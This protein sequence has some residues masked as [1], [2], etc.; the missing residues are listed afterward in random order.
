MA[1]AWGGTCLFHGP[2]DGRGASVSPLSHIHHVPIHPS[3]QLPAPG[4][5]P[6]SG[7]LEHEGFRKDKNQEKSLAAPVFWGSAR[8]RDYS[9]NSHVC[10]KR[11]QTGVSAPHNVPTSTLPG[12]LEAAPVLVFSPTER[13]PPGSSFKKHHT[14]AGEE[15]TGQKELKSALWLTALLQC[16]VPLRRDDKPCLLSLPGTTVIPP[17]WGDAATTL[18]TFP[19]HVCKAKGAPW[20][21]SLQ[22][23]AGKQLPDAKLALFSMTG[24]IPAWDLRI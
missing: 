21:T 10:S 1:A 22:Q 17:A 12:E 9:A 4:T 14:T 19:L 24:L 5:F 7:G 16:N 13:P 20:K 18:K 2:S 15:Q 3:P 6:W 23:I 8:T 11:G